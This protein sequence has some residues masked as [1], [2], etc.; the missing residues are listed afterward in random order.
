VTPVIGFPPLDIK[1]CAN[2]NLQSWDVVRARQLM[3]LS[4]QSPVTSYAARDSFLLAYAAPGQLGLLPRSQDEDRFTLA[5][6]APHVRQSTAVGRVKG[7]LH[8]ALIQRPTGA[9]DGGNQQATRVPSEKKIEVS[10]CV[11][12]RKREGGMGRTGFMPTAVWEVSHHKNVWLA[13]AEAQRDRR[14][15]RFA[16]NLDCVSTWTIVVAAN[17]CILFVTLPPFLPPHPLLPS[18]FPS[19]LSALR[20]LNVYTSL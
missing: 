10:G 5:R 14:A 1:T 2:K 8:C 6:S 15:Q 18:S 9:D 20:S 16:S 19:V 4:P 7:T 11:P 12:C 17:G 13:N 3:Q